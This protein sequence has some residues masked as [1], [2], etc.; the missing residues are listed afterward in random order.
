[1]SSTFDECK[2]L[3]KPTMH[4][5]I[6][7]EK[8][9]FKTLGWMVLSAKKYNLTTYVDNYKCDLHRLNANLKDARTTAVNDKEAYK[10][11]NIKIMENNI[12]YLID[13]VEKNLTIDSSGKDTK[14]TITL[15]D[16]VKALEVTTYALE[17]WFTCSFKKLGWMVLAKN[18]Y[19]LKNKVQEY[20]NSVCRLALSLNK[21]IESKSVNN[22]DKLYDL[23]NMLE[24]VHLLLN[25]I[26]S[27]LLDVSE[28]KVK[29][30]GGKRRGSRKSSK[31]ASRKVSRP[32]S[33]KSSK[34]VSRKVKKSSRK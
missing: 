34:K 14:H 26:K 29:M 18:K 22:E 7:W 9:M 12:S 2:V 30:D 31:K 1:M 15:S 11:E 20:Y 6:K 21:K 13:F 19:R 8:R 16:E 23:K 32:S 27:T 5:L 4:G 33:R 25:F 10:V 3:T 28:V 17:G 24:K